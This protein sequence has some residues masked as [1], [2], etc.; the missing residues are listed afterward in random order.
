MAS[1]ISKIIGC[2][3]AFCAA[4]MAGELFRNLS[5]KCPLKGLAP[6]FGVEPDLIKKM[7]SKSQPPG[8]A[9]QHQANKKALAAINCKG[10]IC[11]LLWS[12]KRDLNPQPSAWES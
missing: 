11:K 6:V 5:E 7:C 8:R 1:V 2:E 12:G 3:C 4:E 9:D 10:F